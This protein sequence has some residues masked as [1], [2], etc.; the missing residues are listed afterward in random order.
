MLARLCCK[1]FGNRVFGWSSLNSF[2]NPITKQ[3]GETHFPSQYETDFGSNVTKASYFGQGGLVLD[4]DGN[5]YL[6]GNLNNQVTN[7]TFAKSQDA[8]LAGGVVDF[9][10]DQGSAL[11][12]TKDGKLYALNEKNQTDHIKLHMKPKFVA[13]GQDA[14][15]AVGEDEK[16]GHTHIFGWGK[17]KCSGGAIFNETEWHSFAE[18]HE[19]RKVSKLINS[20]NSKVKKIKMV[21]ESAV[22]LLENGELIAW[23]DNT[24]GNLGVPRSELSKIHNL[25]AEPAEPLKLN[26]L[27]I[28]VADFDLSHNVLIL[29]STDG[30]VYL[31]GF[32]NILKFKH[33]PFFE[34]QKV[35]AVGCAF[36]HYYLQG[37]DGTWYANRPFEGQDLV[38]YYGA[39]DL[40]QLEP[41]Y[42]GKQQISSISGKYGSVLAV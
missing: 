9:D 41:H 3:S 16:V 39:L 11:F 25:V 12:V 23:G 15:L 38:K 32:D 37:Q 31:S 27:N 4:K 26:H 8:H 40:V 30:Q 1:R 5:V 21:G 28:K 19:L 33:I 13:A 18:P 14:F 34:G 29:L 36:N 2:I 35:K 10:C 42:F 22:I 24:T 6:Q 17:P 7:H 20:K